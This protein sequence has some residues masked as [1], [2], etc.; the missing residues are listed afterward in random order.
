MTGIHYDELIRLMRSIEPIAPRSL[1]LS[2]GGSI[3]IDLAAGPDRTA[4]FFMGFPVVYSDYLPPGSAL[5]LAPSAVEALPRWD[6]LDVARWFK[7]PARLLRRGRCR[8]LEV[9][10]WIRNEIN[11]RRMAKAAR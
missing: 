8:R 3:G 7:V 11:A 6:R 10:R 9:K 2:P 4:G 1:V 5:L